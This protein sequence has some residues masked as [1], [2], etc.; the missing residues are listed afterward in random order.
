[1]IQKKGGI[2]NDC[3]SKYR[4][5]DRQMQTTILIITLGLVAVVYLIDKSIDY[6]WYWWGRN[7]DTM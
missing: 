3:F 4:K 7:H 5:E 2:K 1:M 6:Y